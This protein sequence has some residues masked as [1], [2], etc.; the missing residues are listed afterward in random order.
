[1]YT[2]TQRG[3]GDSYRKCLLL[4]FLNILFIYLFWLHQVLVAA[5]GLFIA[6]CLVA[7]Y[8]I[9]SCGMWT[10]SC[11]MWDLVPRLGTEP[12]PPALEAW[13]LTHWTTT[14]VRR[15]CLFFNSAWKKISSSELKILFFSAKIQER[16][17]HKVSVQIS[18]GEP[19]LPKNMWKPT[20]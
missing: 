6:A 9:F 20:S 18:F 19:K 2:K 14:K 17:V 8:G 1:M 5:R 10:L 16:R 7:A 13:S 11:G 3:E 12:R 4:F 15:K